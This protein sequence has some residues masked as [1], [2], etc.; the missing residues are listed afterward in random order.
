MSLI[1]KYLEILIFI[2]LVKDVIIL[3]IFEKEIK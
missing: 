2:F 1:K 3:I